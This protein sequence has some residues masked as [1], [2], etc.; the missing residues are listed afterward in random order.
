M[1][2]GEGLQPAGGCVGFVREV[3]LAQDALDP[4]VDGEGVEV[5]VAEEQH[6]VGDLRAHAT[7]PSQRRERVRPGQRAQAFQQVRADGD[8]AGGLQ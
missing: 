3:P 2:V 1:L 7:E 6:A 4:H 8:G 5:F